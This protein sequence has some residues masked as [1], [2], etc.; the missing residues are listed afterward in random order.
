MVRTAETSNGRVVSV[1][2]LADHAL[3][4]CLRGQAPPSLADITWV[5]SPQHATPLQLLS[6]RN[7]FTPLIGRDTDRQALLDWARGG[8]SARARILAGDHGSGK[9]R[10]AAEVAETLQQEGWAAGFV[11][12]T[13]GRT[14]RAGDA[15]TLLILDDPFEAEGECWDAVER[16]MREGVDMAALRVLVLSRRFWWNPGSNVDGG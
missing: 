1:G 6:W 4:C 8:V 7:R 13:D 3:S 14:W 11:G 9:T 2:P 16:A 12:W 10:L 5:E 15:G